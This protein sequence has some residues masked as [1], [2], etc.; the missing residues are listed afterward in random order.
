MYKLKD[1]QRI[2]IYTGPDGSGRKTLGKMVSTAF[3]M[4]T[5]P[6]FTTRSPRPFENN[7]EDYHFVSKE[8]FQQMMQQNEFLE[9]V[10][11]DGHFYGIREIDIVNIFK[12]HK[13][14]YLTLN[15]EGADLL[16]QM[17]GD[18]AIRIFVY[19]DRETVHERQK[20]RGDGPE[21]IKRHMNH[22]DETMDYKTS[23]EHVYENY[24]LPQVSYQISEM[25]ETYL[26]RQ[27][28]ADDY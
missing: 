21:D 23:C 10:E 2:F 19:A 22:Y 27:L 20:T 15:P 28:I 4:Q 24:D 8:T 25:I 3:D 7:G 1:K 9:S 5:V 16:K 14:V 18:K 11:I 17:Y 13:V 6:S 12:K 26:D